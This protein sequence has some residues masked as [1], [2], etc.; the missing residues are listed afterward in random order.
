MKFDVVIGNPP[1]Q[2]VHK[3]AAKLWPKFYG[4]GMDLLKD[5]GVLVF[6]APASWLKRTE[7]GSWKYLKDWDIVRL[8]PDAS[9]WFPGVGS[10]FAVPTIFKR[11]YG[12]TTLVNNEFEV[13]LHED[14]VPRDNRHFTRETMRF[15][16]EMSERRIELDVR[17]GGPLSIADS[18]LSLE[19]TDEHIY[20][21]YYTSAKNRRSVWCS[22]PQ[23]AHGELKLIVGHYGN[24][25]KT[26]EITTKGAGAVS[27]YVLG[28][29]EELEEILRLIQHPDNIRWTK[30]M[31]TDAFSEPLT[32]VAR[33]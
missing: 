4:L 30:L 13:N 15:L 6:V 7:R 19:R 31:M 3:K 11:P 9:E 2:G 29:Q 24:V 14:P 25:L 8:I 26:P 1:F 33:V 21:T 10:S 5:N 27:R 18:R 16:K 12:G 28:T 20:E 17:N 32:Y 22:E 23:A